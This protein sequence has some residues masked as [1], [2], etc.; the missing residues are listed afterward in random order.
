M[1][2]PSKSLPITV[3]ILLRLPKP[4]RIDSQSY[5]KSPSKFFKF[6]STFSQTTNNELMNKFLDI[7]KKPIL[8]F[9][10]KFKTNFSEGLSSLILLLFHFD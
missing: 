1:S 3:Y 5:T 9:L 7:F 6:I 10:P 4:T 8:A 2:I